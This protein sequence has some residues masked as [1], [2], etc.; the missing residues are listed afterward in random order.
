MRFAA[1]DSLRERYPISVLCAV[2][3]VSTSG[4]HEWRSRPISTRQ[5]AN[6]RLVSEIR[7][8]HAESFGSVSVNPAASFR[9]ILA[10]GQCR[11]RSTTTGVSDADGE[12]AA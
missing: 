1:I 3:G 7:V 2:L 9:S 8:L 11:S 4:Y 10:R 6:E 12:A 5:R